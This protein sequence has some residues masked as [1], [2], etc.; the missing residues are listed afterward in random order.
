M[1][2]TYLNNQEAA[3]AAVTDLKATTS[4]RAGRPRAPGFDLV[5]A[6]ALV[7]AISAAGQLGLGVGQAATEKDDAK[8]Q[9]LEI[10]FDNESQLPVVIYDVKTS[11]SNTARFP[12]PL[13]PDEADTLVLA[14]NSG[15]DDGDSGV[16]VQLMVGGVTVQLDFF[17]DQNAVWQ[18]SASIKG[19]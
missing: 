18:A 1:T 10:E 14:R 19:K 5:S 9:T 8:A 6:T 7:S 2:V 16:E 4:S 13:G 3:I 15:F 17:L 11:A 12:R